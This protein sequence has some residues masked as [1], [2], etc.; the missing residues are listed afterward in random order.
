MRNVMMVNVFMW[1]SMALVTI[2]AIIIS[3]N[4]R[5]AFLMIIASVSTLSYESKGSR[6]SAG[7]DRND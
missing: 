4:P 5:W 2:S 7:G 3:K 6:K 1:F